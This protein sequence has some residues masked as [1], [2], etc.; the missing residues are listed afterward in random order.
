M[1]KQVLQQIERKVQEDTMQRQS[2]QGEIKQL[3]E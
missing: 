1:I 3:V 2:E